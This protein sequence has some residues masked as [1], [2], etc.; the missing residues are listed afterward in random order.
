M[1]APASRPRTEGDRARTSGPSLTP[2]S[3]CR[4]H[5]WL[6]IAALFVAAT[7]A[8]TRPVAAG[9][10]GPLP[11]A[12]PFLVDV[13]NFE[14]QGGTYVFTNP[15]IPPLST[16]QD[17]RIGLVR[18]ERNG[19]AR[20]VLVAPESLSNHV[21][22]LDGAAILDDTILELDTT[23]LYTPS[24]LPAGYSAFV[25]HMGICDPKLPA[26][27]PYVCG[28]RD[29]YDIKVIA[30]ILLV[31]ADPS[32]STN[33]IPLAQLWSTDVRVEVESPKTGASQLL[34]VMPLGSTH[35]HVELNGVGS[36]VTSFHT[37]MFVGDNR[38]VIARIDPSSDIEWYGAGGP[39]DVHTSSPD[40]VYAYYPEGPE[41]DVSGWTNFKPFSYAPSDPDVNTRFG[42]AKYP[43]RSPSGAPFTPITDIRARYHWVD[44][45]ANNAFFGTLNR[46]LIDGS[47]ECQEQDDC[48][49][50]YDIA[51]V[52]GTDCDDPD[53]AFSEVSS[54]H[55][56]WTMM[57]LWTH[58]KMVLL[59]SPINHTDFSLKGNPEHHRLVTLFADGPAVRVG[60]G[61][62]QTSMAPF[63]PFGWIDTTVQLGATES[64]FNMLPRAKT[65]TPRDVVWH[66]TTGGRSSE[67]AFDD[68]VSHR[69]L[70]FSPMNA[71][72]EMVSPAAYWDGNDPNYSTMR[73]QNAAT[74][75]T[76]GLPAYGA[77]A[78]GNPAEPGRIENVA[79]GG[80]EGRGFYLAPSTGI[81]YVI[82]QQN[83]L[84]SQEWLVSVFFDLEVVSSQVRRLFTFPNGDYID[85]HGVWYTKVCDSG[86][87]CTSVRLPKAMQTGKWTHLAYHVNP[88]TGKVRVYQD[89]FLFAEVARPL[90]VGPGTFKVGS[91]NAG[92]TKGAGGWIDDVKVVAGPF[93]P[94]EICNHA[95]GTVVAV[96]HNYYPPS[97]SSPL[98]DLLAA[99]MAALDDNTLYPDS[100]PYLFYV[101]G[102]ES[103]HKALHG[104]SAVV[105]PLSDHYVCNVDY[106]QPSGISVDDPGDPEARSVRRRL[107]FPEGPIVWNQPRPPSLA[108]QF[109]LSCHEATGKGGLSLAAL[110]PEPETAAF[111]D[112][113]R[114]PSQ[115]PRQLFGLVPAHY[116]GVDEPATATFDPIIDPW[117]NDG[118]L[119][120]WKLDEGAG[121]K[122]RNWVIG[123][124]TQDPPPP[125]DGTISGAAFKPGAHPSVSRGH[126]LELDGI[127]DR[128]T[129]D[130]NLSIGG[131][132]LTLAA[133][134]R[135]YRPGSSPPTPEEQCRIDSVD[136]SCTLIAKSGTALYWSLATYYHATISPPRWRAKLQLRLEDDTIAAIAVDLN[137]FTSGAWHHLA[138]TY[139]DGL[140]QIYLDGAL[141]G[142]ASVSDLK[143]GTSVAHPVTLGTQLDAAGSPVKPF[144]GRLDEV[145]IYDRRLRASEV[146]ELAQTTP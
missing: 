10:A 116:V 70:I 28:N 32:D 24:S 6:S 34:G 77:V 129:I 102:R 61:R 51:C 87:G 132:A 11:P 71:L 43:F 90:A 111:D 79:L 133:W 91:P 57:G 120:L 72:K 66:A 58:G 50:L 82:P 135:H 48:D 8:F 146:L 69:T 13:H 134:L 100:P 68:Y 30:G 124:V 16:T 112:E 63:S 33:L 140:L 12:P 103:I 45:Q 94:E 106:S 136:S 7:I 37:P 31:D 97:T 99:F 88:V 59:D 41:C 127:D 122:V 80:I 83:N 115:P 119:Y 65:R 95:R 55:Q 107:L 18:K 60:A 114:Q 104:Q 49:H 89:G 1:A 40:M 125:D 52:D 123:D 142:T 73:L 84:E 2:T 92:A 130:S 86:T 126:A 143:L 54:A 26:P 19:K 3:S 76:F 62:E 17:N 74:S 81:D 46:A 85:L 138:G 56:G 93:S 38:L 14:Q 117:I 47:P 105:W 98:R 36:G 109:C 20:F 141:V 22:S 9:A 39:L 4:G 75:L 108:N 5:R 27:N 128:V 23:S 44:Q 25:G 78:W 96:P 139:G 21:G 110:A 15:Y 29:C 144:W 101:S 42:F 113:R 67:V 64:S 118:P 53:D 131:N 137:G 145:R 121:A 35:E